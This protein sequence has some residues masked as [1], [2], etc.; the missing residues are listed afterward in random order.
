MLELETKEEEGTADEYSSFVC[1]ANQV[2]HIVSSSNS[3]VVPG[4]VNEM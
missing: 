2:F 1:I 3:Y 4:V